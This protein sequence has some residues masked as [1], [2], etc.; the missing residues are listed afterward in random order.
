LAASKF[1]ETED[2]L[3]FQR[4]VKLMLHVKL[5]KLSSPQSKAFLSIVS[6]LE[7]QV[8][9]YTQMEAFSYLNRKC[10]EG[11]LTSKI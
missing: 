7:E 1:N 9:E 2:C 10:Q 6:K 5:K 11:L 3:I 8:S 4:M